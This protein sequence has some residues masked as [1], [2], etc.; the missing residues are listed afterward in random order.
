MSANTYS[1]ADDVG[2][3]AQELI[4]THHPH[5]ADVRIEYV[6]RSSPVRRRD[7]IAF[8][9][10]SRITGMAAFLA[11]EDDKPFDL[12]AVRA[13]S[14][15]F[16]VQLWQQGWAA[17][18]DE[19]KRR[20]LDTLLRHLF[21][22]EVQNKK[23]GEVTLALSLQAPDIVDFSD[24]RDRYDRAIDF[25]QVALAALSAGAE[26]GKPKRKKRTRPVEPPR[27]AV[28]K[29]T[30]Q[31]GDATFTLAVTEDGSE[32]QFM[33][34]RTENGENEAR[35][36]VAGRRVETVDA[37]KQFFEEYVAEQA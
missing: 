25:D 12:E 29:E 24:V 26:E 4:R 19:G 34:A 22:K 37:A 16:V 10:V 30:R 11:R 7:R 13:P 33:I 15:F 17:L 31:V 9:A 8:G 14:A 18:L 5:L 6:W 3:L 32:Y 27:V 28:S 2:P 20:C 23:T 21:V 35:I 36:C 1:P